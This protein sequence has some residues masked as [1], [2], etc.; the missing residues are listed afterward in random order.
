MPRLIDTGTRT[1]ELAHMLAVLIAEDGME[2]P[3]SRRIAAKMQLNIGTLYSHFENRERLLRVLSHRIGLA[4]VESVK[5]DLRREGLGALIR[6]DEDGLLLT[7]AWLGVVALGRTEEHVG[8]SVEAV[9]EHEL[10]LS[11]ARSTTPDEA[12]GSRWSTPWSTGFGSRP[13]DW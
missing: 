6:D 13:P 2:A 7:R 5:V 12:A 9:R 4:L 11:T 10:A 3:S 1:D 8:H